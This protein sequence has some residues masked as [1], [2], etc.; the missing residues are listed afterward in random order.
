VST[1]A[2]ADLCE[3]AERVDITQV[4]AAVRI[5]DYRRFERRGIWIVPEKEFFSIPAKSDF[6]KMS[7]V[8]NVEVCSAVRL[9]KVKKPGITEQRRHFHGG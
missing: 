7:Q 1:A 3:L 9:L 2:V 4:L 5:D 6:Y 8:S